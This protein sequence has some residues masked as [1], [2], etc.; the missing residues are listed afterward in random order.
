[1][2]KLINTLLIWALIIPS[3]AWAHD[4]DQ[5]GYRFT[6]TD[7]TGILTVHFTPKTAWDLL[8]SLHAEFDENTLIRLSDYQD[9]FTQYF[10]Q[11]LELQL[12][13]K[14]IHLKFREA[15]FGHHDASIQFELEGFEDSYDQVDIRISSFTEI[16]R[17]TSNHVFFP[18]EEEVI[19][20]LANQNYSNVRTEATPAY[21]S[22]INWPLMAMAGI[23]LL[24]LMVGIRTRAFKKK[25][26]AAAR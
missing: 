9:D 4:P 26:P 19:L 8:L 11:T 17:R 14:M 3:A 20:N 10:N 6:Q 15:E 23:I 16:Y 25:I 22:T 21:L 2:K 24:G 13:Q 1:M 18:G 7:G 5:I 12:G